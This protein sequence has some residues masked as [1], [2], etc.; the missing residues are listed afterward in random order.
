MEIFVE[1]IYKQVKEA[2]MAQAKSVL[3]AYQETELY[4]QIHN[5][6][7]QLLS[8]LKKTV[9][10]DTKLF[11]LLESTQCIV[12]NREALQKRRKEKRVIALYRSRGIRFP[13][14]RVK[15]EKIIERV[16]CTPERAAD[17][18]STSKAPTKKY[19]AAHAHYK[20]VACR[21]ADYI[22]MIMNFKLFS[23]CKQ[24]LFK[25]IEA[26]LGLLKDDATTRCVQLMADDPEK[27]ERCKFLLK[28]SYFLI[29]HVVNFCV[30]Y[31]WRT[32]EVQI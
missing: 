22:Q 21:F 18:G 17:H 7:Q 8:V 29:S 16:R 24:N 9:D 32:L 13:L 30:N 3:A 14:D 26:Q 11:Y 10:G 1:A 5:I 15:A 31:Y 20:A 23:E 19:N 2:I 4:R 28:E 12:T 25:I 6:T 27:L